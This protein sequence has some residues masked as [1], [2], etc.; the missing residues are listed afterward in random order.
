MATRSKL[1][2]PFDKP[3]VII[4]YG[5]SL[6]GD[7]A[8]GR[9]VAEQISDR[10]LP[11]VETISVTQLLPELV[12]LVGGARAVIFVD[13][14]AKQQCEAIEVQELTVKHNSG[15]MTHAPT[16]SQFLTLAATI[17]DT[18]PPAWLVSVRA[19]CFEFTEEL[20][21]D[22]Q[23]SVSLAAREVERLIRRLHA[24]EDAHT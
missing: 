2:P 16:P 9:L 19:N 23:N 21:R 20:S 11:S 22:T 1:I 13:A 14:S 8:V 4:G 3:I 7:D 24:L 10:H 15:S 6:R 17:C 12:S 5:S 18:T